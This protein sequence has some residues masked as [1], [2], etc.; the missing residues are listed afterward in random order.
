MLEPAM[1]RDLTPAA[2]YD[3]RRLKERAMD[4]LDRVRQE[5]TRQA[6]RFG[7]AA[8]TTASDVTARIVDT[9]P[10]DSRVLDL[11]CGPGIVS[12]ALAPRARQVVA[13]DLTP[14]MLANARRRCR[15]A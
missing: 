1:P 15:A 10:A 8:A 11:A 2:V 3:L 9:V 5:F 12:A 6:D 13:F 4:H 14:Q 7:A